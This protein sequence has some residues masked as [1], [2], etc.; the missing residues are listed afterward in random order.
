MGKLKKFIRRH[1]SCCCISRKWLPPPLRKLSQGKVEKQ[2]SSEKPPL[3]KTGSDKRIKVPSDMGNKSSVSE[4]EDDEDRVPTSFQGNG[5]SAQSEPTNGEEAEDEVELPPPMKP[6]Q[7][8]I[9]VSTV[10][11]GVPTTEESHGKREQH[12]ENLERNSSLRDTKSSDAIA[13]CGGNCISHRDLSAQSSSSDAT[14]IALSGDDESDKPAEDCVDEGKVKENHLRKRQ[15]VL[16]ELVETEEAYVRDLSLIVDGYMTYMRDPNCEIPIPEDLKGG[17]DKI[18]FGNIKDIY[19]WHKNFFLKELKL[20]INNITELGNLF[21]RHERNLRMYVVYCKNKPVSEYIVSEYLDT[22]FEELRIKLEHKLQ[23]CDLLIKPVQRIMKY[24]LL[25]KDILK[26]TEKAGLISEAESLRKALDIM[27]DVPKTAND[28]MDFGRLQGFEGKITAQ[29]NLLLHGPLICSDVPGANSSVVVGKNKELQVFLFEQTIIFSEAVGKKTQFTSPQYF[30]K[31][32]M[33]VNKMTMEENISEETFTLRS[34]D[35]NKPIVAFTCQA[36]SPDMQQQWIATINNILQTQKDFLKAIQSPIAYQKERTRETSVCDLSSLW[37][38][39]CRKALSTPSTPNPLPENESECRKTTPHAIQKAKTIGIPS[40][41]D[42]NLVADKNHTHNKTKL[43]F[44]EGFRNTLRSKHKNDNTVLASPKETEKND[45]HRR[46]SEANSPTLD[47]ALLLP[48][49]QARVVVDWPDMVLGEIIQIIQQDPVKGYLVKPNDSQEE[50]WLP[51]HVLTYHNRKHWPFKF[52]K[53]Q[54]RRSLDS[55]LCSETSTSETS[56]PEFKEKLRNI[57]A[58][59]GSKVTFKCIINKVSGTSVKANWRKI[60]PDPCALRSNGRFSINKIVDGQ[61]RLVIN[62]LKLSDSGTYVCSVSNEIG[63]SQCSAILTVTDSLPPL[64]EPKIQVRSCSSVLIEWDSDSYCDFLVQ[65]CKLGTGEWLTAGKKHGAKEFS[66]VVENLNPG[67]TYSFRVVAAENNFVGLPS[68]AVTLPVADGLRWQQEQFNRRYMELDEISRGRFAVVR[69]AKD[70]GTGHEVALKQV[71]KRK[72]HHKVTQ[73]EYSLLAGMQ[74]TNIIRA[75]ALF[76][77]A[78]VPG[79]DTIVLELVKGP[80]L[81]NFVCSNEFYE[82]ED[83]RIYTKQL[84]SA[85][86]WLH[87][88]DLAHLDIKPEN[89]MV[90]TCCNPSPILKLVDFGNCVNTS[91]NVILPPACL[92]FAPPELVLGQPVGKHTDLWAVGVF[93]YVFLSG[94]SPFLDDSMEETTANILK[95]DFCFPDEFFSDISED[96]KSLI[97]SMLSLLPCQRMKMNQCLESSWFKNKSQSTNKLISTS[98]LQ[99]FVRRRH[100][101]ANMSSPTKN[102]IYSIDY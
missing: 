55:N 96:A 26:H 39:T 49:M 65:F 47:N 72:Q 60:E 2:P 75:L 92:E 4:G 32:H 24:Q 79:I 15:F 10:P 63:T 30:Y 20:R 56:H 86:S 5:S 8:S 42:I 101:P 102:V 87:E 51:S 85:V 100:H 40:E 74:H 97:S 94:V 14:A 64:H 89:V 82:E 19:E 95:C 17:K 70:R 50:K 67:E 38:P 83:V 41:A 11:Q 21:R 58:Q 91:A 52:K 34:T 73:A 1:C 53:S 44:F 12:T 33:Q 18:V 7:E 76:D 43:T 3:K 93:L 80:L 27:I 31:T 22:Y 68:I 28:M 9:L 16:S 23:I 46:W 48:G 99:T 57:T 88:K 69:K 25:L 98:R 59:C 54:G 36:Y 35:P 66:Y 84:M 81:F 6:I 62:N 37:N 90:D 61:A 13:E 71:W 45:L 78:P 77:N 29:D